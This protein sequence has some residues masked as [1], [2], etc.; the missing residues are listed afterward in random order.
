MG[1]A[2]DRMVI[3]DVTGNGLGPEENGDTGS[4]MF[5]II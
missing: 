1:C 5:D 2:G 4:A 3:G